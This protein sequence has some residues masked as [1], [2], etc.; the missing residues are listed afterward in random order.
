MTT[1]EIYVSCNDEEYTTSV[2]VKGEKIEVLEP[3]KNEWAGWNV[4]P[5]LVDGFKMVFDEH[6]VAIEA[7]DKNGFSLGEVYRKK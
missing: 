5:V 6:V 1:F 2:Q 3:E 7:Y 4:Y